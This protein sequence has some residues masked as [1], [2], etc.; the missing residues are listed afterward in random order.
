MHGTV[1]KQCDDEQNGQ[2]YMIHITK[3]GRKGIRT[4]RNMKTNTIIID[5]EFAWILI[6]NEKLEGYDLYFNI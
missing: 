3:M 4:A 5:H 6:S 1:T 2:S